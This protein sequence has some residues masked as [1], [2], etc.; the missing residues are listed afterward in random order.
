MKSAI[1]Y[2]FFLK[3]KRSNQMSKWFDIV[4]KK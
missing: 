3:K 1:I 4:T 2:T